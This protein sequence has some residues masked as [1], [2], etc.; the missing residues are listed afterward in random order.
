MN[1]KKHEE[2]E[3]AN[4]PTDCAIEYICSHDHSHSRVEPAGRDKVSQ[5]PCP[6]CN[7]QFLMLPIEGKHAKISKPKAVKLA[8][9]FKLS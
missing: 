3:I 5:I 9:E 2:N 8:K 6:Q 7:Y 1:H 4:P